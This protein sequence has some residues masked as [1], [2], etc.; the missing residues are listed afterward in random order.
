MT[1]IP[2]FGSDPHVF[3]VNNSFAKAL[4]QGFA[5]FFLIAIGGSTVN[6]PISQP[7]G[8]L[9]GGFDLTGL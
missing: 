2:Q 5:Y 1:V 9:D 3:S 4:C 6:M 7:N 8:F